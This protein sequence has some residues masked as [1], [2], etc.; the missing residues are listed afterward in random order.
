M[1]NPR[2]AA[3]AMMLGLAAAVPARA[4]VVFIDSYDNAL[5]PDGTY[6]LLYPNHF[7]ASEF[8]DANNAKSDAD[9]KLDLVFFRALTYKHVG[10]LPLAFQV[11]LPVGNLDES[12]LFDSSSSGVGDLIFGPGVFLYTSE[13]TATAVSYWFYAYAPTGAFDETKVLNLGGNRWYFE[14]QL[15]VNQVIAKKLV[16][17]ANVNFY[18]FTEEPE[19]QTRSPLRFELAAI[20]GYQFTDKL[21]AGIHGGAYWDLGDI[22]TAGVTTPDTQARK[23]AVGPALS[24]QWTPKLGTTFRYTRDVSARNDFV[25]NDFWLRAS[26]AF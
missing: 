13:K 2:L 14:H 3:L 23:A 11:I 12:S 7:Q 25:G 4:A 16:I 15:A 21:L 19:L 8:R 6:A 5:A 22:E 17:D 24:Y 10:K 26:Y 1:K 9:L 20:A 18:H